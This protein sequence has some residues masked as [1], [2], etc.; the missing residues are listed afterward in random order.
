MKQEKTAPSPEGQHFKQ[1]GTRW[2]SNL[3]GL[4]GQQ[5]WG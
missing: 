2:R 5:W 3:G 4:S 1:G